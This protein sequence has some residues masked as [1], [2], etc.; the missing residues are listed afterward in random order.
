MIIIICSISYYFSLMLKIFTCCCFIVTYPII[1]CKIIF[2]GILIY[3]ISIIIPQ[4][5]W[6]HR[7]IVAILQQIIYG[8]NNIKIFCIVINCV[9]DFWYACKGCILVS[10]ISI[11]SDCNSYYSF[12]IN[13]CITSYKS[14]LN[15]EVLDLIF[16]L[17][18]YCLPDK[19]FTSIHFYF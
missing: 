17:R 1:T 2:I 13:I 6:C 5:C 11:I 15:I 14:D 7:T 12:H 18:E 19:L 9:I 4:I 3:S 10:L 8:H 16:L